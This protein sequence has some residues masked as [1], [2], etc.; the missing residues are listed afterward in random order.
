[1]NVPSALPK[2]PKFWAGMRNVC[3]CVGKSVS[4]NVMRSVRDSEGD[5]GLLVSVSV[6]SCVGVPVGGGVLLAVTDDD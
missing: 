6:A 2:R 4:V 3:V 5:G 1:M